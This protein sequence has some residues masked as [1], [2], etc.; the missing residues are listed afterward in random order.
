MQISSSAQLDT[1]E[2]LIKSLDTEVKKETIKLGSFNI[3]YVV[4]GKG[5]SVLLLHG[6]NIGW[7]QWYPNISELSKHFKVYALDLPGA[8]RSTIID[9]S[10]LDLETDFVNV[11][12]KFVSTLGL[13]NLNIVGSSIGGWIAAKLAIRKNPSINKLV[14]VDSIGFTNYIRLADRVIGIYPLAKLL[15]K[16]ILKPDR[17]NKKIEQFMRSVFHNE[18]TEIKPE[19]IDYFY[20][21]MSNSHN[22]LLISSLSSFWGLRKEFQLKELL[23]KITNQT[24]ILW[25]EKDKLMPPDKCSTGF[26]LIP[27]AKVQIINKGGHIPSIEKSAEFNKYLISFLRG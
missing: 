6:G 13:R 19:F 1:E 7:G 10:K 2:N 12:E 23:P 15:T 16:T 9:F 11:V 22:L 27:N 8:G 17:E 18:S 24:L 4:S 14:L 26:K 21:T 5:Q 20:E 25:G 3:N